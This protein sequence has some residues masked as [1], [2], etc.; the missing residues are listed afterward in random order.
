M[1][2]SGLYSTRIYVGFVIRSGAFRAKDP[3]QSININTRITW[4]SL[5]SLKLLRRNRAI[6]HPLFPQSLQYPIPNTPSPFASPSP[7]L[8]IQPPTKTTNGRQI[9]KPVAPSKRLV[10]ER[11]SLNNSNQPNIRNAFFPKE[12]AEIVA[13]R[14]RRE[15]AWHAHLMM[16]TTTMSNIESTLV[17]FKDDVE[18][19]EVEA[20][21]AYLRLAIAN[22][23][24]VDTSPIP[25]KVP[26]HSRPTKCSNYRLGKDKNILK[27]VA[28]A[29]PQIMK[30]V[31][32]TGGNTQ[33]VHKLPKNP[34]INQITWATIAR[35]G[36]KKARVIPSNEKQVASVSQ[37]MIIK[38]KS[39]TTFIDK[40][41][42][43]R[44]SKE[45]EWRKLSPAGLREVIVKKLSISPSLIGKI[46]SQAVALHSLGE[47]QRS[48]IFVY[49]CKD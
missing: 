16:Y 42:F 46:M 33:E 4:I 32:S 25:P 48:I 11:P 6:N 47:K 9:L 7:P 44:I 10:T 15:R 39:Q 12:L 20:F 23:A 17:N 38:E 19:E 30:S 18:K 37:S 49:Y 43:V 27:N 35:N 24:A 28:I 2:L 1:C 14:Q 41:L 26:T 5:K 36:Q 8:N 29:T 21:K 40:R 31:A 34:K 45:H 22:F 3:H 13:T